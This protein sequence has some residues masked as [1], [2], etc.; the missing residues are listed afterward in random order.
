V[1]LTVFESWT[2]LRHYHGFP[3]ASSAG[4]ELGELRWEVEGAV[5][6]LSNG[7]YKT[8]NPGTQSYTHTHTHT[9]EWADGPHLHVYTCQSA[10]AGVP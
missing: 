4:P 8:H 5:K 9:R 10:E 7:A 3:A 2:V 6:L 1:C